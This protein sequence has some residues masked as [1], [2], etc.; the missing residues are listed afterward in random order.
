MANRGYGNFAF[1]YDINQELYQ[2]LYQSE[3][4]ARTHIRNSA[5]MLREAME[6]F[7]NSI[8]EELNLQEYVSLGSEGTLADCLSL[9]RDVATMRMAGYL[10]YNQTFQDKPLLP[11][12]PKVSYTQYDGQT[13]EKNVYTFIRKVGNAASHILPEPEDPLLVFETVSYALSRMHKILKQY[14]QNKLTSPM[15]K[16]EKRYMPIDNF[17]VTDSCHPKDSDRSRCRMEFVAHTVDANGDPEFHALLR[18]YERKDLDSTF[19]LRNHEC[20]VEASKVSLSS[21]PDGMT[22][23]RELTPR[24]GQN[25]EFYI[26]AYIFNREAKPLDNAILKKMTPQQRLDLCARLVQCMDSLHNSDSPIYHRLLNHEC[27]Y[28]SQFKNVWVPYIIKMDYAKIAIN[29]KETVIFS[30]AAANNLILFREPSLSKFIPHEWQGKSSDSTDIDW[31]KVDVYSLGILLGD[32]LIGKLG[33]LKQV[34]SVDLAE[35]GVP[36]GILD[37]LDTMQANTIAERP[38]IAEAKKVFELEVG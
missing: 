24:D 3:S 31:A 34:T 21:V 17:I 33:G 10:E 35:I 6:A 9:L 38:T 29:T 8:T 26:I 4:Q 22:R 37:I 19:M 16:F 28:V 32:I 23:M 11:E 5:H 2:A 18:L 15:P 36:E 14:Y 13:V 7:V 20:F 30:A 1:M 12:I 25:S 27:I